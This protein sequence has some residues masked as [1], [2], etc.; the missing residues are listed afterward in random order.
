M[1][2]ALVHPLT[3]FGYRTIPGGGPDRLRTTGSITRSS[4]RAESI[5]PAAS[6]ELDQGARL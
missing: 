2:L 3:F 1:F 6:D 5:V 4:P